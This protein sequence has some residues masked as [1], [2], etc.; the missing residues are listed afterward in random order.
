[1]RASFWPTRRQDSESAFLFVAVLIFGAMFIQFF[2][3]TIWSGFRI[4]PGAA[5]D[6]T[7][8]AFL[9]E[10]VFQ[11][12]LGRASL[13]NPQF[14]FP[15]SG[16]LGY[17]DAF[18]LDQIFYAPLRLAGVEELLAAQLTFML[19]SMVGS[20]FF[21][22]LLVRF[23]GVRLWLA[24]IA[25]A[26]FAFPHNLYM[27]TIHPQHFAIFF[28]PIVSYLLLTSLFAARSREATVGSAF[29]GGLLL[30]LTFATGYYMAWFFVFFLMFALPV[31]VA[32]GWA[33][34]IEFVR[35]NRGRVLVVAAA[36]VIGFGLGATVVAWIYLPALGAL[37]SLTVQTYLMSAATFRDIVNVSDTN[38]LWGRLL[39]WSGVIPV[40]R[41]QHTEVVL[42]ATPLL[43]ATAVAGG[44]FLLRARGRTDYE[45][46]AAAIC[47]AIVFA[48]AMVYALTISVRGV[49]SP[50]FLVQEIIPG[51]IAIR[52]GFRSQV[53]SGMFITAAFALVAEAY[54]RRGG[55]RMVSFGSFHI[56]ARLLIVLGGCIL[57]ALEQVDVQ[58]LSNLDRVKEN[59]L[60]AAVP[61][62]PGECRV[63]AYYNDGS[64][65]LQAIH[66]D[67]MRISQ[68]FGLPTVNGYSGG[69]PPGWDFGNVWEPN[70]LDKVRKW[71]RDNKVVGTPCYYDATKTSWS[72]ID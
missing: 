25:S 1:M 7:V 12:L 31:F 39:R 32:M 67:A 33:P 3:S 30:A 4:F 45:R 10:H 70:Y 66:V 49:W 47:V 27:K 56:A 5:G 11:S 28:L 65:S 23:F 9:H 2:G 37:R 35:A 57:L 63:F 51:A 43:V 68:R 21:I 16:V 29:S 41:L 13:L 58:S 72:R 18:L 61:P 48:F 71:L 19:L 50:F 64:R 24:V 36:A 46:V 34:I 54:L 42:A 22:A 59:V 14:Y 38:L 26:I 40:G 60:L 53:V 20:G 44:Y 55:S 15:T 17:T 62:P 52:V 6:A 69:V 8:I